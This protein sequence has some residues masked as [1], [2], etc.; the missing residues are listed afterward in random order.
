MFKMFYFENIC[1][2]QVLFFGKEYILCPQIDPAAK[3]DV[4]SIYIIDVNK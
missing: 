4:L 3:S 2:F 1:Y